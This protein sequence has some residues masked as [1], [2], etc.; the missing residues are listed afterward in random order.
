MSFHEWMEMSE[1]LWGPKAMQFF[2]QYILGQIDFET[3]VKQM[4]EAYFHY[5]LES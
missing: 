5:R 4:E 1:L 3:C 2:S